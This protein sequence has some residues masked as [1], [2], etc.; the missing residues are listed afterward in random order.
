MEHVAPPSWVGLAYLIA[1]VLFIMAL[2]GLSSPATL[3]RRQSLRHCRHD[4]RDGHHAGNA[5]CCQPA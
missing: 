5:R 1:G 4:H 3:A 2:R